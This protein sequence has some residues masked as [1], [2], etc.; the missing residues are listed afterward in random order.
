[1]AQTQ[2]LR[3]FLNAAL[4][5]SP[6]QGVERTTAHFLSGKNTGGG[7]SWVGVLCDWYNSPSNNY[8]YGEAGPEVG[9]VR[10][11]VLG[12]CC[13]ARHAALPSR[14]CLFVAL[15]C[16]CSHVLCAC[17]RSCCP[18]LVNCRLLWRP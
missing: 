15:V 6:L 13:G 7:I 14:C 18:L 12:N 11:A 4:Q 2:P 16:P 17:D 9:M 8:A 5:D 3:I 1:M 10:W